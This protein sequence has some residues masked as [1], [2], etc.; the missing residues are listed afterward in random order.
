MTLLSKTAKVGKCVYNV[1]R[2]F[3]G[4]CSKIK[5]NELKNGMNTIE[6]V[7]NVSHVPEAKACQ[8]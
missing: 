3:K 5:K 7:D 8:V 4:F 1:S 6:M 2:D